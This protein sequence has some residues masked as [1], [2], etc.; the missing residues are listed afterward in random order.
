MLGLILCYLIFRRNVFLSAA[1]VTAKKQNKEGCDL[2]IYQSLNNAFLPFAA[3]S[4]N[5]D[6]RSKI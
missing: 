3:F 1:G 4:F 6:D 2:I 5:D